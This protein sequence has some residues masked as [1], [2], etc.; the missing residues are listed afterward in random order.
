M[1]NAETIGRPSQKM[2]SIV[3]ISLRRRSPS[4]SILRAMLEL[5]IVEIWIVLRFWLLYDFLGQ[6]RISRRI[7]ITLRDSLER[8]KLGVKLYGSLL[9]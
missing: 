4:F 1:M 9:T 8:T 5:F 7:M 6:E 3:D 2:Y